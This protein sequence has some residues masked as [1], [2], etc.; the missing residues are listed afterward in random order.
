MSHL[1]PPAPHLPIPEAQDYP[2]I[3]DARG[4]LF[5]VL[6][7]SHVVRMDAVQL[8][9]GEF[10]RL[11]SSGWPTRARQKIDW[12]FVGV[13]ASYMVMI[14]GGLGLLAMMLAQC[15]QMIKG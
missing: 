9:P 14:T 6:D 3:A 2:L 8:S 5:G 13:W 11:M 12:W 1:Q 7:H 4:Y 10:E 15:Y